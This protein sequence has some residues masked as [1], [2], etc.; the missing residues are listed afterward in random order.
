MRPLDF[1][2]RHFLRNRREQIQTIGPEEKWEGDDARSRNFFGFAA[3]A[4][5]VLCCPT[6]VA[7]RNYILILPP[8]SSSRVP[9]GRQFGGGGPRLISWP[10]NP[11]RDLWPVGPARLFGPPRVWAEA[12]N[13]GKGPARGPTARCRSPRPRNKAG[14]AGRDLSPFCHTGKPQ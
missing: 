12:T 14:G 2:A 13:P 8:W 3:F 11:A 4:Q 6:V 9:I 1:N 10:S 7:L 5:I